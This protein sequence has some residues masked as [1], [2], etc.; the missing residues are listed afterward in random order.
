[1]PLPRAAA[2]IASRLAKVPVRSVTWPSLPFQPQATDPRDSP[3]RIA[4]VEPLLAPGRGVDG[5]ELLTV[6]EI[7]R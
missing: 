2:A 7:A 1:M 3:G 5:D 6:A 4:V